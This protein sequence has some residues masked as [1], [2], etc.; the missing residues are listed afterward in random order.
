VQ[1]A[2][3]QIEL[4]IVAPDAARVRP[5]EEWLAPLH[6][7]RIVEVGPYHSLAE[8]KVKTL[9]FASAPV[10]AF[11]EDHSFPEPDWA[12]AL[13]EAHREGWT[14][15]APE[16]ANANPGGLLSWANI[17]IHFGSSVEPGTRREV[18][19]PTS[20]H[21]TSYKRNVLLGLGSELTGL[22]HVELFLNE[23][24]HSSGHKCLLEPAARTW[25][26][27]VSRLRPWLRHHLISG[28][29][30]GGTRAK[31][32]N[33]SP[34]RRLIYIGGSPLIPPLRL[35]RV[36]REIRRTSH[37]SLFPKLLPALV[38]GLTVYALG[39][40]MGYLFGAG[41]SAAKFSA[42]ELDRPR[43]VVDRDLAAWS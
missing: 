26:V 14:A 3:E 13:I 38:A 40:A 32:N 39:E 25:H 5:V 33:W 16:M 36:R 17:F 34:L 43:F 2:R 12:A 30:Y 41:D 42:S 7:W 29:L 9:P 31:L 8:A 37:A 22:M 27:N 1:T 21:N 11:A 24:L 18:A 19:V 28:R 35:A 10:I 23:R 4:L 20:S 15:V 6:S